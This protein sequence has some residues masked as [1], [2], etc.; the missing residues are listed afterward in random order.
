MLL[1]LL[2]TGWQLFWLGQRIY[3]HVTTLRMI[4]SVL[5][6]KSKKLLFMLV[7]KGLLHVYG[8]VPTIAYDDGNDELVMIENNGNFSYIEE[9]FD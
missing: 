7:K 6:G 2:I 1:N 4:Y 9:K 3:I 5:N 8:L